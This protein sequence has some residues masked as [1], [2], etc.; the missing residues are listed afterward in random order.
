[1]A[2]GVTATMHILGPLSRGF[3]FSARRVLDPRLT[4]AP[5]IPYLL[6]SF[7]PIHLLLPLCNFPLPPLPL[8][9]SLHQKAFHH[10][11]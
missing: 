5:R 7:G 6:T 9:L 1:M 2:T 8:T 10:L 3:H 11:T 4:S